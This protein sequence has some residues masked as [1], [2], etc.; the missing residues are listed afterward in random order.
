MVKNLFNVLYI[1]LYIAPFLV[2][3][4]YP[5]RKQL[6]LHIYSLCV[7]YFILLSIQAGLFCVLSKQAFWT[8]NLTQLYRLTFV[9]FYAV[10]ALVLIRE[11]I[12]KQL[13]VWAIAFALSG[14]VFAIAH[15]TEARFFPGLSV[16]LPHAVAVV[17]AAVLITISFR[18]M[19]RLINRIANVPIPNENSNIWNIVWLAP[20]LVDFITLLSTWSIAP[21]V[22]SHFSYLVIRLLCFGTMIGFSLVLSETLRQIVKNTSLTERSRMMDAQISLQEDAYHRLEMQISETK[23]ARHDLRHHLNVIQSYLQINEHERLQ[24]Y[25]AEYIQSLPMDKELTL[26]ENHAVNVIAAHYVSLANASGISVSVHLSIP[27]NI[28]ITNS[29][30]CIVF[31][32][33]LE[34]ALEACGRMQGSDKHINI[35]AEC[36]GNMLVILIKNSF[37]GTL[38]YDGSELLSAKREGLGIGI[39]SV[40]A[41]VNKY[42][43]VAKFEAQDGVFSVSIM[44]QAKKDDKRI[45]PAAK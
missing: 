20:V 16:A 8:V 29:D 27:E 32:N 36:R 11:N 13:Y 26:C 19:L 2:V 39:S 40:K 22:V 28:G 25:L 5:F 24:T 33:C 10:L 30:I 38:T 44:M 42:C 7:I 15:F 45:I 6:R 4:F 12:F 34:N 21:D 43:G 3:R 14:T 23:A 17:V 9:A 18:L 41:I 31:S 37:D 35:K 1:F